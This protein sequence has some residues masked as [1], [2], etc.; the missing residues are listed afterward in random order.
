MRI[1]HVLEGANDPRRRT[2][3]VLDIAGSHAFA[4]AILAGSWAMSLAGCALDDGSHRPT[5]VRNENVL[6]RVASPTGP[7][8][9]DRALLKPLPAPTC[10]QGAAQPGPRPPDPDAE[11]A[12]R[13]RA[14]YDLACYRIADTVARQRLQQLQDWIAKTIGTPTRE[15]AAQLRE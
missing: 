8:L 1:A 12:R 5:R 13:I 7:R 9:P 6:A 10:E 2:P 15:R 4:W 3:A 14:E 11:L